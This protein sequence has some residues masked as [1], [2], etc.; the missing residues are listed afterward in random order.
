MTLIYIPYASTHHRR[1][2]L[3]ANQEERNVMNEYTLEFAAEK[4]KVFP[5]KLP[6]SLHESL[7]LKNAFWFCR[8]RWLTAALFAL[9]G[10]LSYMPV[11]YRVL[12]WQRYLVWPFVVAGVL[13]VANSVF[14]WL[15]ILI[16][17]S[18]SPLSARANLWNQIVFDLLVVTV[19]VNRIGSIET[20]VSFAYLFHIVLACIF[21]SR[22]ESFFIV[23]ISFILFFS[24]II[25][26]HLGVI[27]GGSIYLNR[28]L[29]NYVDS[30]VQI[31]L[32]NATT[33][34]VIWIPVWYLT[35]IFSNLLWE[36]ER[37]L[38]ETNRLLLAAQREKMRHMVRT[39]HEL[40][41]PFAAIQAT[42]QLLLKG[43]SGELPNTAREAVEKIATRSRKLTEEIQ[44]MLQIANLQVDHE[45]P[46]HWETMDLK[47]ILLWSIAQVGQVAQEHDIA[48]TPDIEPVLIR[49]VE[50]QLKM[51]F[52]NI[53]SNAIIYSKEGGSVRVTS[54]RSMP[55]PP[56]V[57]VED[58]GIGIPKE[59]L[60]L[61]FEE[62]YRTT[63]AAK[64]NKFSTGLG[65]AIVRRV[66]EIHLIKIKVESTL[67]E[68][69]RFI[70]TFLQAEAD[71][72]E[73]S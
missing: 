45:N 72:Q 33:T 44:L 36:R 41:A 8:L 25:L 52:I 49:G 20:Y 57:V 6:S 15:N 38:A 1:P 16:S 50:D 48:I 17:K 60:P 66:A 29:R 24:C 47:C 28:G 7:Y 67:N 59:K 63:E 12:G 68:G 32:F 43:Y 55:G 56:T 39:T 64:H 65:L 23:A 13:A 11:I 51:M 14:L 62:Y 61:I 19:A 53:L 10:L 4:A 21:F 9:F 31:W 69:S 42:T 26:E 5:S 54:T 22:F 46:F 18:S 40:K 70:L 73:R 71:P 3:K 35:S 2:A 37:D 27:P 30:L 34:V 58:H